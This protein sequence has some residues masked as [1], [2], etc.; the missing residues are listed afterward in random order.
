[1]ENLQTRRVTTQQISSAAGEGNTLGA[2]RP[3]VLAVQKVRNG[4]IA[5]L[6]EKRCDEVVHD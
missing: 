3:V 6:S 1:M 4:C 2:R 5:L